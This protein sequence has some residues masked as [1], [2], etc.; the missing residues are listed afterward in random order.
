[1][2]SAFIISAKRGAYLAIGLY[3]AL[4]LFIS[5]VANTSIVPTR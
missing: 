4:V 3:T 5:V 2:V 1:M